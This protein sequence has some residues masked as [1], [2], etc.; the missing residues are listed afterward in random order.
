MCFNNDLLSTRGCN[1]KVKVTGCG[2]ERKRGKRERCEKEERS[3][4]MLFWQA[5]K[6]LGLLVMLSSDFDG[7]ENDART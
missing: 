2:K 7:L 1:F 4:E 6:G 5:Y 3:C